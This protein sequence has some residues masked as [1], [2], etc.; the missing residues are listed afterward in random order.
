MATYENKLNM[1]KAENDRVNSILKSRLE[2]IEAWKRKNAD[3]EAALS[4][5][6]LLEKDKKMFED[7]FNHQIKTIEELNFTLN[8]LQQENDEL[9]RV[10]A[11]GRETEAKNEG[12]AR[13]LDRLN[14]II[15]GK[16]QEAHDNRIR[17]G[18]ME[19]SIN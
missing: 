3:L 7:K 4:R 14:Q 15:R 6:G 1:M 9:R 11:R 12:L 13:E 18:K 2:E 5:M 10:E 19:E 16:E 17:L 8:Q